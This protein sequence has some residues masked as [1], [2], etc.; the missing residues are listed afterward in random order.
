MGEGLG[1]LEVNCSAIVNSTFVKSY[2]GNWMHG[3]S[4]YS[5][6]T[7]AWYTME[8][9]FMKLVFQKFE[10]ANVLLPKCVTFFYFK[11]ACSFLRHALLI[12]HL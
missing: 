7:P 1:V 6:P 12:S 2:K 5:R 3:F 4:A 9:A 10:M 8:E 11:F